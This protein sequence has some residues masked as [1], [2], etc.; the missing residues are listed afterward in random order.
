MSAIDRLTKTIDT[1]RA[2]TQRAYDGATRLKAA[3]QLGGMIAPSMTEVGGMFSGL[4]DQSKSR[5]NY[6]T[7]RNWLYSAVHALA[8]EAAGQPPQLAQLK[9]KAKK[10]KPKATKSHVMKKMPLNL[11]VKAADQEYQVLLDHPLLKVLDKPN[12]LQRG[13]QFVYSFVASINLTGWAFIVHDVDKDGNPVMYALPSTW[14]RPDHKDGPFSKF[15][16]GNPSDPKTALDSS[17]PLTQDNVSFAY[18]PDPSNPLGAV[19]PATSQM[20]AIRIDEN[21]QAS[22][23]QHFLNFIHPSVIV[24]IGKNPHP[25]VPGGIRPRLTGAQRRQVMAAVTKATQGIANYG[26]PAIVDGLV[27]SI[28]SFD[29]S[30]E[31]MGWARSEDK[32]R[33]RILSAFSVHPYILGEPVGVGGYAQVVN[34]EKRFYK[35]VNAFLSM[36]SAIV[37]GIFSQTEGNENIEVWYEECVAV[38]P[39]MRSS[40]LRFAR[41]NG[42]M[43]QDEYRAELGL[44][45]DEDRNQALISGAMGGQIAQVLGQLGAGAIAPEQGAAFLEGMGLPTDLAKRI[46]GVGLKKE[47]PPVAPPAPGAAQPPAEQP[48]DLQQATDQLQKAVDALRAPIDSIDVGQVMELAI[49][50]QD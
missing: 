10:Q 1:E 33:T 30:E 34:I 32:V 15:Y 20:P 29:R 3:G 7:F 39:S 36:L 22:Q 48:T 26:A 6:A 17:T 13:W 23:E 16:V 27:E 37:T 28:T 14:V 41:G 18:F 44:P 31:E 47:P 49:D 42:D 12:E 25:D 43:T 35:R 2:L 38:D 8:M 9:G 46:A 40:E 5:R 19:A 21:I 50:E 24:T 45:P 4:Q 11:R